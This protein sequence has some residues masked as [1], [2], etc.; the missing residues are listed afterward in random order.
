MRTDFSYLYRSGIAMQ[1]R[2]NDDICMLERVLFAKYLCVFYDSD[3]K[4][5]QKE[6]WR[7]GTI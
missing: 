3:V 4:K 1:T 2:W 7:N 6:E 5:I